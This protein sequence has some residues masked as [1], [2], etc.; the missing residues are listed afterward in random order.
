MY[1]IILLFL[2]INFIGILYIIKNNNYNKNIILYNKDNKD[3]IQ[4]DK[5]K[6]R[7]LFYEYIDHL[8][9]KNNLIINIKKN[10]INNKSI[11]HKGINLPE[12]TF[13]FLHF[14]K[15]DVIN[16]FLDWLLIEKLDNI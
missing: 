12:S 10:L 9:D 15:I 8:N 6:P 3:S 5:Y 13:H 11:Y 14:K 16:K 4:N 2:I 7:I 1:Y